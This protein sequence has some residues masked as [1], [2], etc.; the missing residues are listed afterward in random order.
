MA[1]IFWKRDGRIYSPDLSTGCLEG[2]TREYLSEMMKIE[3]VHEAI[4][5]LTSAESIYLTSAGLGIVVVAEL[6]REKS[7]GGYFGCS[8]GLTTGDKTSRYRS[9][10]TTNHERNRIPQVTSGPN[11]CRSRNVTVQ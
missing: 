1:N 4:E 2:T 3:F 5:S 8:G 7:D 6:D 9:N 11:I 10:E